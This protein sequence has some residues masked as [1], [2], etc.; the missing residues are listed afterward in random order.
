MSIHVSARVG[1]AIAGNILAGFFGRIITALGPILIAP[2]MIRNWGLPVYGEWLVLTAIPTYVMIA[3]DFGL[4]GAVVNRMP[5]LSAS[6]KDME[7]VSLYRSAFVALLLAS[8][9]F[10]SIGWLIG[11]V[12]D[13]SWIGVRSLP[14]D[15]SV[16]IIGWYCVYIFIAQQN[17]LISGIY[18]SARRNPRYSALGT[19]EAAFMLLTGVAALLADGGPARYAMVAAGSKAAFFAV[20]LA[21][22]RRIAPRFTLSL[23]DVAFSRVKPYVV[24]GFGHAGMPLVNALQNQGVLLVLGA[25]LG[26]VAVGVFQTARVLSNGVKSI[27]AVVASAV[28]VELPALMGEGRHDTVEHLLVR[29]LQLGA[30]LAF[31]AVA[32][33]VVAGPSVYTVWLHGRVP[34][35]SALVI[36]LMLSLLPAL[37]GQ[38]FLNLIMA[39]NEIHRVILVLVVLAL[40]S[41]AATVVGALWAGVAGAAIGAIVWEAGQAFAAWRRVPQPYRLQMNAMFALKR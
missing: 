16:A 37:A 38:P 4:A 34:Y 31:V 7:A 8:G 10:V 13:W 32:G 22:S 41:L 36:I 1:R 24:P 23:H 40:I 5:F 30:G 3:P 18:K 26:P 28:N 14:R 11:Y 35:D 33:A 21:D 20:V 9:A 12:F 27:Y 2:L 6:G 15:T 19:I 29:N 25:L 39:R 17:F